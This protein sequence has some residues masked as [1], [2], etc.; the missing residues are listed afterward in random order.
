MCTDGVYL[1]YHVQIYLFNF[2]SKLQI[3]CLNLNETQL[4][5]IQQLQD[6]S[7]VYG[8]IIQQLYV[9]YDTKSSRH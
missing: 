5:D 2:I 4:S 3:N 9:F 1:F 7:A 8:K 6:N